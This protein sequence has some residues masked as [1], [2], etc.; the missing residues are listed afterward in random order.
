[1]NKAVI[2]LKMFKLPK[3]RKFSNDTV[4]A[5]ERYSKNVVGRNS[6]TDVFNLFNGLVESKSAQASLMMEG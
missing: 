4:A 1:V 2:F 3:I 6:G 5:F